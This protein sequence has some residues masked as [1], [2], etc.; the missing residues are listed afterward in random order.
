ML[1][2]TEQVYN[3]LNILLISSDSL[4]LEDAS[5]R[6]DEAECQVS[7]ASTGPG[8]P[9][10]IDEMK[11][12]SIILIHI[13]KSDRVPSWI[14]GVHS[15]ERPVLLCTSEPRHSLPSFR[16]DSLEVWAWPPSDIELRLRLIHARDGQVN[17][18]QAQE[19]R[20][21][22]QQLE[23]QTQDVMEAW[24]EASFAQEEAEEANEELKELDAD[25]THFFRNIS[26]KSRRNLPG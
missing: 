4:W 24:A 19:L 16:H 12:T 17:A 15:K 6:L 22:S 20:R 25:K 18:E 8:C 11:Q 10:P 21:R 9:P 13:E 14:P 7:V 3:P 1:P 26:Q 23:L 5:K 2:V